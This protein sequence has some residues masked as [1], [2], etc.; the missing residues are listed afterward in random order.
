MIH[1]TKGIVLRSVKYGETSLIVSIFTELF[2]IQSYMVNGVRNAKQSK[3]NYF[4]SSS[5]LDMQVYYNEL[6]NLQRIKEYKWSHIYHSVLTDVTKNAVALYMVELL[7][8]SLKQPEANADLFAFAED[9]FLQLDKA[10]DG[11]TANYPLYFAVQLAQFFGFQ[12]YDEYSDINQIL[13]M[14]EGRFTDEVPAHKFYLQGAEASTTSELLKTMHPEELITL[15]LNKIARR[16]L[17]LAYQSYYAYHI[18]DFGLMRTLPV[19]QEI[20]G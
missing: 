19:L 20:L 13:D 1:H 17:L 7:Q 18:Q 4:Q 8:R 15:K 16:Q 5:I 14:Q 2:G 11:V 6:K 10:S 9:A 12:F 3:S